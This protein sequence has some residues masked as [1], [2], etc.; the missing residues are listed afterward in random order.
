MNTYVISYSDPNTPF[1]KGKIVRAKNL[2]NMLEKAE[3]D[4]DAI[5]GVLIKKDN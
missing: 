4:E 3:I 1:L 5:E 2:K